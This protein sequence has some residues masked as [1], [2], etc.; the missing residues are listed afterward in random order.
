MNDTLKPG[1]EHELRMRVPR[2]KTVPALFPESRVFREMPEVFGF[3]FLVGLVEWTCVEAVKPHLDWPNE[4]T[5]GIHLDL[6][7][8]APTPA[9]LEVVVAVSL[10]TVEDRWLG[11]DIVAT[12][13]VDEISRGYHER[14]VI[15]VGPYNDK[16]LAKLAA[17]LAPSQRAK[18]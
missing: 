7:H 13:G 18:R 12:D 8:D 10:V 11:F 1:I 5:V 4:Q 14:Y 16:V 2:S 17:S 3:G 6:S 15:Q 9:G